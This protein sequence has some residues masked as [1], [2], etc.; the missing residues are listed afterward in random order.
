[1]RY[2]L[3]QTIFIKVIGILLTCYISSTGADRPSPGKAVVYVIIISWPKL[4]WWPY[5]LARLGPSGVKRIRFAEH[6]NQLYE[7]KKIAPEGAAV[8][9]EYIQCWLRWTQAGLKTVYAGGE[10]ILIQRVLLPS[11]TS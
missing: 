2:I 5:H 7:Q 11:V 4:C 1:L 6:F 3:Y 9:G 10:L 8:L